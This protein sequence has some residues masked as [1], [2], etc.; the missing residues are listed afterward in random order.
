[1]SEHEDARND[2]MRLQRA[3]DALATDLDAIERRPHLCL[4]HVTETS[5]PRRCGIESV[6]DH[7]AIAVE[8][9]RLASASVIIDNK[10]PSDLRFV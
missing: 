6:V 10:K 2:L 1:M 5:E 8:R 3:L 7:F 9:S 4:R